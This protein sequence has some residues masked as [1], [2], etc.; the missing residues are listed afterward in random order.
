MFE[1]GI[2]LLI[3]GAI[4]HFAVDATVS[5]IDLSTVGT[6]LLVAG[7]VCVLYA[8]VVGRRFFG[9]RDV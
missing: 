1:L 4:L 8:I 5:G 3:L 9:P 2:F 6:I 7:G